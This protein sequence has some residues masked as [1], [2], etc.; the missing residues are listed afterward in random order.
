MLRVMPQ[1]RHI[2]VF[3]PDILGYQNIHP[4]AAKK[5][6][7]YMILTGIKGF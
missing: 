6:E 2:K 4:F 1:G 5:I 7:I 3:V